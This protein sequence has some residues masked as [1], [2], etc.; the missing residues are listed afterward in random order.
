MTITSKANS[1]IWTIT[2]SLWPTF[3]DEV[4]LQ[5]LDAA[6]CIT[7]IKYCPYPNGDTLCLQEHIETESLYKM[8]EPMIVGRRIIDKWRKSLDDHNRK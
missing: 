8:Y 1:I 7:L 4:R 6:V 2:E 5:H 3:V